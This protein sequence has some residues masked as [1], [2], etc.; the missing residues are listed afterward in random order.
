MDCRTAV[1]DSCYIEAD[2]YFVEGSCF[3]VGS[4][5]T[6]GDMYS[7]DYYIADN[8]DCSYYWADCFEAGFDLSSINSLPDS[9]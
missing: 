5:Y 1:G 9:I 8:S 2:N 3:E 4:C 7:G 6:V